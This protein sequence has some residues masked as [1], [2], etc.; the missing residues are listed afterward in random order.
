MIGGIIRAILAALGGYLVSKM[1]IDP[2]TVQALIGACTTIIVAVWSIAAK[3]PMNTNQPVNLMSNEEMLSSV[4]KRP[5]K[6][7]LRRPKLESEEEFSIPQ[8]IKPI[9]TSY[10]GM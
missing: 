7:M 4:G 8:G 6:H 5:G 10:S 2:E 3:I 9:T 1:K